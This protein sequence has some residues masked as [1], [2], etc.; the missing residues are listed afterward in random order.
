MES[1]T[2]TNRQVKRAL[3]RVPYWAWYLLIA[4]AI[5]PSYIFCRQQMVNESIDFTAFRSPVTFNLILLYGIWG[6]ESHRRTKSKSKSTQWL[7]FLTGVVMLTLFFRFVGG[8]QTVF[9]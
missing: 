1:D 6:Y 4:L 2:G 8:I 9:G 3:S 5:V 7:V